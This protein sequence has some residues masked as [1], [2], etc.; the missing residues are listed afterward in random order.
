MR[1]TVSYILLSFLFVTLPF[2]SLGAGDDYPI[3]FVTQVP[4]DADFATIGSTFANHN[5]GVKSAPRGGDLYIRFPDGTLKNLTKLAGYGDDAGFQGTNSIAVRDP[6]VHWDGSK[7]LFSMVIGSPAKQYQVNQY[8]W[9]IY[10]VTGLAKEDTPV[11]TKIP[12]QPESYNNITPIYG[13]D[14]R[15]LFTSDRP[16]QGQEHLYPLLDEYETTPTV[17]G[18]WRLDPATGELEMLDHA[19]SGDF[20]PIIDSFGRVVFTKWDHLQRDQQA[21][22]DVDGNTFGMFTYTNESAGAAK[23]SVADDI[24]SGDQN[25]SEVFPEPRGDRADLLEGTNLSGHRFNHFFPWMMNE[26]GSGQETLNH[27][28]RHELHNYFNRSFN[29]D[30]NLEEFIGE[31]IAQ[32]IFQLQEDPMTSGTYYGIDAPEFTTHAS[33]EI[34][35]ITAPPHLSADEVVVSTITSE[36]SGFYRNPLP[37]SNGEVVAVHAED[38]TFKFRLKKLKEDGT[39]WNAGQ[40]LTPG[41]HKSISFWNPDQK[42]TFDGELWELSPVEVRSR[43]RPNTNDLDP[44]P[45]IEKTIF[46]EEGVQL[47]DI[48]DYLNEHNLALVVGRNVTA[49]DVADR[50]QPFNLKVA[51]T[52]TQTVAPDTPGKIY[53]ISHLQF[54][55][56]DLLRGI[57]GVKD[58]RPGRRVLARTLHDSAAVNANPSADGPEGSVKISE[59]G[60]M[61]AFLPAGRAMS[62]QLTSPEEEAVVRERVWVTFRR[63]EVRVCTSC[64]GANKQDQA[65]NPP[66]NNPPLALRELLSHWKTIVDYDGEENPNEPPVVGAITH[67]V[68]DEDTDTNGIQFYE[69]SVVTYSATASDSENDSLN[70]EWIYTLNNGKEIPYASGTGTVQDIVF[71]YPD[72]S[73]GTIYEWILR[74]EDGENTTES[75]L[76][77]SILRV[78]PPDSGPPGD[79]SSA[80]LRGTDYMGFPEEFN[81]Y[82]TDPDWMPTRIL[83]VSRT[84]SNSNIGTNSRNNPMSVDIVLDHVQAGDMVYFLKDNQSYEDV[85]FRILEEHAATYN[86]PIVF[87]GERNNDGS[88]GVTLECNSGGTNHTSSCFNVEIAD[89][90]AI[91]GFEMVGGFYGVRA[92]GSGFA[93]SD[94]QKGLAVLNNDGHDQFKDPF[95]TGQSSWVVIERNIAHGAGQGDGH[96]IYLSNG[97][98]WN[99]VR[100]NELYDNVGAGFQ[101]NADPAFTCA[102]EGIAFDDPRCDGAAAD[103]QGQGVSEHMLLEG[104]FFHDDEV[105]VNFTSMRNSVVRNNIF[106][107]SVRHNTSFWQESPNPKLGSH[108]NLVEDNLFVGNNQRHVVQFVNHSNRNTARGNIILG[109]STDGQAPN[110]STILIEMDGTTSDSQTLMENNYYIGGRL[111]GYTPNSNEFRTLSFSPAWFTDAPFADIGEPEDWTPTTL[112]P[113][114]QFGGWQPFPGPSVS[115]PQ[116]PSSLSATVLSSSTIQL[117]WVDNSDDE[118]QFRVDRRQGGGAFSN[119]AAV[120]ANIESYTDTGLQ[121]NT[122][123]TYRVRAEN[124]SGNSNYSNNITE[125]TDSSSSTFPVILQGRNL[126]EEAVVNLEVNKPSN[127]TGNLVLTLQ[128]FDADTVDEGELEINGNSPI[129]LFGDQATFKN[130]K[131]TVPIVFITP[132]DW[133]SDG[134]NTLRFVHTRTGGYR[135]ESASVDFDN[136]PSSFPIDLQGRN[137]PEDATANLQVEK[138]SVVS[139]TAVLTLTVFDADNASE[140]ELEINGNDPI[141]L[142]GDQSTTDN[143]VQ[144][145]PIVLNT[146]SDWW[147]D[148][149]NA[150]RFVHTSTRGY[151][152]ENASVE[153]NPTTSSFPIDL[154]SRNLPEEATVNLIVSKPLGASNTAALTMMVFDADHPAEGELE[155]NGNGSVQLFSDQGTTSNDAMTVPIVINTP[156]DWWNDGPNTLRFVHTSTRGYRIESASVDFEIAGALAKNAMQN[157][158]TK[159]LLENN[160]KLISQTVYEDAEDGTAVGWYKYNEGSITNNNEGA[161]GSEHAI[162]II[163]DIKNDVFRLADEDGSDWNNGNELVAEF[164]VAFESVGSGVVYFQ[165]VTDEGVK[166]LIYTTGAI[167]ENLEPHLVYFDLGDIADGLWHTIQRDLKEDLATRYPSATLEVVKGLFVYGTLKLDDIA[168]LHFEP[169]R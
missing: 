68:A 110:S 86:D 64:H 80:V 84:G 105:G 132:A 89:Y 44:L 104:N 49:R 22:A 136:I 120:G 150:L 10:E 43:P 156:S 169:R 71:M 99:I 36:S 135:I 98:D 16:F 118:T 26:D 27:I 7:A 90:I 131:K 61:A 4:E 148:G 87:Y 54:F 149:A 114:S 163:G 32:N 76:I 111:E 152:V 122:T 78:S 102:D 142:F 18:I 141:Q 50:Q 19:P 57:G 17:S 42:E 69:G 151:R 124:S 158:G 145:V 82:Y 165:I 107:P 157:R 5:G 33:G 15:I 74:V 51:G 2:L 40:P 97:G 162:E 59:D 9:Q 96:G 60:S 93:P 48:E 92:V 30:P 129:E 140:G 139:E 143:D 91:D 125:T 75:R 79:N 66:A 94:N 62:W 41:I 34:L 83:Y 35:R 160:G 45:N 126:P 88:L 8:Y 128:V 106:G 24:A 103:G 100:F 12:N 21:D 113:F 130:D 65:G 72:D 154:Q 167:P 101:I 11:V 25:N 123:Y 117:N 56:A 119:V 53:D 95:F 37:L 28:G 85:N 166:F 55:Q 1:K 159:S 137:L 58:P 146:P 81:R 168:L 164:S 29:D 138:P 161:N 144:T 134:A 147:N 67:D 39:K 6:S 116:A 14:D 127:M 23:R 31:R 112:A 121:A 13:T 77:V 20:T 108:S 133:W 3:L 155:I 47:T 153:F 52:E 63:G 115:P 46:Q 73:A 38:N 109:V 70:W